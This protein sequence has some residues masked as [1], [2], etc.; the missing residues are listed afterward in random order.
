MKERTYLLFILMFAV[1]AI[2]LP[3][4][5]WIKNLDAGDQQLLY[6]AN[7]GAFLSLRPELT[8]FD[9]SGT[10]YRRGIFKRGNNEWI[11]LQDTVRLDDGS[12]FSL[13]YSYDKDNKIIGYYKIIRFSWL[14]DVHFVKALTINSQLFKIGYLLQVGDKIKA[15]GFEDPGSLV[16]NVVVLT[17]SK[18]GNLL[19]FRRFMLNVKAGRFYT[20][21]AAFIKTDAD[22]CMIIKSGDIREGNELRRGFFLIELT[23]DDSLLSI[24]SYYSP[25]TWNGSYE[26]PVVKAD[27]ASGFTLLMLE[28]KNNNGV[29]SRTPYLIKFT[30]DWQL[31]WSKK[32]QPAQ[33]LS[34]VND[35]HLLAG[36]DNYTIGLSKRMTGNG[37]PYSNPI[38]IRT[39]RSGI[40]RWSKKYEY[41]GA[42][43][44]A[45]L[46]EVNHGG[47]LMTAHN[48]YFYMLNGSGEIPGECSAVR[49]MAIGSSPGLFIEEAIDNVQ[50][51]AAPIPAGMQ[52]YY[53]FFYELT[54]NGGDNTFCQYVTLAGEFDTVIERSRFWSYYI[55]RVRFSV[56]A[57][58]LPYIAKFHVY[59]KFSGSGD[60]YEFVCEI[61]ALPGKTVYDE[62]FR[63][64]EWGKSSYDY[65]IIAFNQADELVDYAYLK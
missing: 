58:I 61:P 4:E 53:G 44:T 39:D 34:W 63:P 55:H 33:P 20:A 36:K 25:D 9:I 3:G 59:R 51:T 19:S 45:G 46:L 38:L 42:A 31:N 65:K 22:R 32:Y 28:Q 50:L 40:V 30:E 54:E 37:A 29:I 15:L 23:G 35:T 41:G 13:A 1:A 8:I 57:A 14:G 11:E 18:E 16:G 60:D 24:K 21:D 43:G 10:V 2:H 6:E 49:E 64:F 27:P 7:G 5:F 52:D 12:F 62:E 17:F 47:M 48:R 56:D 26:S